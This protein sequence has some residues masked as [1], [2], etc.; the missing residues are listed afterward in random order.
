MNKSLAKD[1]LSKFVSGVLLLGGILFVSAGTI[2]YTAGWW[3]LALLFIP[4]FL[5]GV[6][7]LLYRPE[8]LERRVQ[9]DETSQ[10]QRLIVAGATMVIVAGLV[11]AGLDFR[12]GW[13]N[14]PTWLQIAAGAVL[15]LSY[16]LYTEVVLENAYASRTITVEANQPVIDT[17]LYGI[18]RHPMYTAN[19]FLFLAIPLV[20]DSWVSFGIFLFYPVLIV[21]RLK[22]EETLK[23][24]LIGYEAYTKKVRYRLLPFIW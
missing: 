17:K 23:K 5:S 2:R 12:F 6:Y 9:S 24:E 10:K 13:T 19:I 14:V 16:L 1:A 21:L 22:E 18:I 7:L 15:V 3:L 20:L 11:G 4:M 8:I